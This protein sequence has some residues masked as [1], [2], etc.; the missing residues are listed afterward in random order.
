MNKLNRREGAKAMFASCPPQAN[1]GVHPTA[2]TVA[3]RYIDDSGRR[4]MP[5]VR[6]GRSVCSEST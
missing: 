6:P 2:D 1:D 5:G 3:L 4:V